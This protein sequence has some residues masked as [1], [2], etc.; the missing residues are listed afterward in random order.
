MKRLYLLRH[1]KSGWDDP[2]ARDFDRPLN[3]RGRKGA[4]LVGEYLHAHHFAVDRIVASP[5]VRVVE[6]LEY[7]AD[8]LGI[9]IDPVWDKRIYLASAEALLEVAQETP[10]E[11]ESVMLV[12]HN[13]GFEDLALLLVPDSKNDEVRASI[14]E[15]LPTMGLVE[16]LFAVDHWSAIKEG[17]GRFGSYVRPRDLDPALGPGAD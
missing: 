7:M 11:A 10:D 14:E 15:K 13:P 8:G 4:R 3:A 1:A 9:H 16:I 6:T 17:G 5:A 12:G 2:V